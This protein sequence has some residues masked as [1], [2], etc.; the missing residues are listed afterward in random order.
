MLKLP[1]DIITRFAPTPSGYLHI[2]NVL[3]FAITWALAKRCNGQIVLRIDD[4]DTTR[5]RPEYVEDIFETLSFLGL[6]YDI[7]PHNLHEFETKYSQRHKLN[8]YQSGL[9]LLKEK[10]KLYACDCS[11]GQINTLSA[12]GLY[13]RKCA[14]SQKS[15]FQPN[16]AW[17]IKVPNHCLVPIND[18]LTNKQTIDLNQQMPDFVVRR[19]DGLPAYQ[20]A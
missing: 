9:D 20:I 7:G 16:T 4:I 13:L 17:R 15:F 11:R 8:R 3:S 10:N 18:M 12:K 2:G 6:D 14:H 19:K 5:Y 1:S